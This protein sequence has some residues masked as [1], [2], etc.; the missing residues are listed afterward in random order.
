MAKNEYLLYLQT[1][2]DPTTQ[3][4]PLILTQNAKNM[5]IEPIL[6][7]LG[8]GLQVLRPESTVG[9][10]LNLLKIILSMCS[11][12]ATIFSLLT[13]HNFLE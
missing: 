12:F 10:Q 5:G 3:Y 13:L 2:D 1:S 8:K 4:A 7:H 11:Q 9:I 6:Y